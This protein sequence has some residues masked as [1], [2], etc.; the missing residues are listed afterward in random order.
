MLLYNDARQS[1]LV[2]HFLSVFVQSNE[3]ENPV[4]D[5]ESTHLLCDV[6]LPMFA[7]LQDMHSRQRQSSCPLCTFDFSWWYS[8][9]YFL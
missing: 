1:M 7:G 3:H 9:L 2:Y 4:T 5:I 8:K 6:V